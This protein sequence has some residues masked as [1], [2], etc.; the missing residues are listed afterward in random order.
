MDSPQ[1]RFGQLFGSFSAAYKAA[2]ADATGKV[3]SDRLVVRQRKA[4]Y[5]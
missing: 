4:S 5:R 1:D 2:P 3:P